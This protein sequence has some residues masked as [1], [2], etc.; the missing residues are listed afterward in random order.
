MVVKGSALQSSPQEQ[1]IPLKTR[2]ATTRVGCGPT[3]AL[4]VETRE[5]TGSETRP[6]LP[7]GLDTDKPCS[8]RLRGPP[9]AF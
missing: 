3:A 2:N 6:A 5:E 7:R 9:V 1:P 8:A 4:L